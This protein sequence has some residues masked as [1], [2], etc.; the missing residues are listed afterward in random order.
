MV[1][2]L[3]LVGSN[4][5]QWDLI[6]A[7]VEFAYNRST[8]HTTSISSFEVVYGQNPHGTLDLAPLPVTHYFSGDVANQA[9]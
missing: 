6:L 9:K 3:S 5:H 4:I 2:L 8:S 7:Q 1:N